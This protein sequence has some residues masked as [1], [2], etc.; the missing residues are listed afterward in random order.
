VCTFFAVGPPWSVNQCCA[1]NANLT[2]CNAKPGC[3]SSYECISAVASLQARP[4]VL[5][6]PIGY[7]K[8]PI[9]LD[10]DARECRP[11]AG[12]VPWL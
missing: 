8:C 2:A 12:V 1:F 10:L 3:V 9:L 7:A 6:Y 4:P 11:K 5:M